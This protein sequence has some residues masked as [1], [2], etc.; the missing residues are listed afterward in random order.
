VLGRRI[1]A[2]RRGS[3]DAPVRLLVTGSIHGTEP[4][5]IPVI[6]RL[7]EL[8]PPPACRCGRCAR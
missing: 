7:R 6:A 8:P 2:V 1:V 3:A 4:A 5:G